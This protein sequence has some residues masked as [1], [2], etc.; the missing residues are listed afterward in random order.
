ME[1]IV[2]LSIT[3]LLL[4]LLSKGVC[5]CDLNNITIGTIRS[6]REIMG[7]PEW[8]VVVVNNC[9]NCTMQ[10][11]LLSCNGFQ[12]TEPVDPTIF[13]PVG[14]NTCSVNNGNS[15]PP[16]Y[17]VKFSYAWDPPFFLRQTSVNTS[18]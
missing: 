8:N 15:I 17:T 13:K 3:L 5:S 6:G 4:T 18:C 9:D 12:T 7:K 1:T 16:K 10:K 11:M 2:K 14:N